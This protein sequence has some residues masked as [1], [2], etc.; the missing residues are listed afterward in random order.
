[1]SENP[2][3]IACVNTCKIIDECQSQLSRSVCK[4]SRC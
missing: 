3:L 2:F 4:M 1:M